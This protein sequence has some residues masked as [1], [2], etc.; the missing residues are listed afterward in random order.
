MR[1]A[2]PPR[3]RELAELEALIREEHV[4]ERRPR[5][6]TAAALTL[7]VGAGV[8]AYLLI[9]RP[10]SG[11]TGGTAE[12]SAGSSD[13][14]PATVTA[15]FEYGAASG[16]ILGGLSLHNI[17]KTSCRLPIRPY[18]RIAWRGKSLTL[19]QSA[20]KGYQANIDQHL[21]QV[22]RPGRWAFAPVWWSNWCGARPWVP[23]TFKANVTVQLGEARLSATLDHPPVL[24]VPRCDWP[25]HP[26]TLQVGRFY[27]PLPEGWTP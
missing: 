11:Q 27:T 2:A 26:S 20:I 23:F 6:R 7:L 17:G 3:A 13:C 5:M 15:L 1:I 24:G 8:A 4:R 21:V 12:S 10:S 16:Q 25:T 14:A 22:L 9:G 18:V 19:K